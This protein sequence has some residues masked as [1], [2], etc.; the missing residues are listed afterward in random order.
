MLDKIPKII[1]YFLD[2]FFIFFHTSLIIFNCFGWIFKH[3]RRFNLLTLSLTAFSWFFLGIWYG[4]GYCVSTDWHWQI[5]NILG[6]PTYS[7]SYI[8]FLIK[9]LTGIL[10]DIIVVNKL[11]LII[12]VLASIASLTVNIFDIVGKGKS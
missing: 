2:I 3:T 5:R 11:T 9:V 6:L 1:L 4:F 12:F 7:Y 10:P 8:G